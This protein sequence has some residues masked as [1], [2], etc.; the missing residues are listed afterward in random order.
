MTTKKQ[1]AANIRNAQKSTGPRTSAGQARSSQN[2]RKHGLTASQIVLPDESQEAFNALHAEVRLGYDPCS[3]YEEELVYQIAVG[4]WRMRRVFRAEVSVLDV[5]LAS[6]KKLGDVFHAFPAAVAAFSRYELGIVKALQAAE[7]RFEKLR[8]A[9]RP[10]AVPSMTAA[11]SEEDRPND[12]NGPLGEANDT[13][14]P[15]PRGGAASQQG[16]PGI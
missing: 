8:A 15:R 4:L 10:E 12:L 3:G 2:S 6:G 1:A 14:G 9:C 16:L 5:D 13:D 11:V 7:N